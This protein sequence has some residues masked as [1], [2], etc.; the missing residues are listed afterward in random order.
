MTDAFLDLTP[1]RGGTAEHLES[2]LLRVS[3]ARIARPF[4]KSRCDA[5]AEIARHLARMPDRQPEVLALAFWMRRAAV[6]RMRQE[7]E[8]NSL[9]SGRSTVHVSARGTVFHIPPRNVDTMFA[10]SWVLSILTGN[11]N[12]IRLSP[13]ATD[14][15]RGILD[16]FLETLKCTPDISD[17]TLVVRFDRDSGITRQISAECDVRVVWGGDETVNAIRAI[18]L[19]PLAREVA[20]PD[21]RSLA[22]IKVAAYQALSDPERDSLAERFFNDAFWF[23]QLG[24]ASPR[25]VVWVGQ[26]D[27]SDIARDFFKRLTRITA[28]KEYAADA[29]VAMRKLAGAMEVMARTPDSHLHWMSNA[30]T[31]IHVSAA[32]HSGESFVGAG[33][34]ESFHLASLS[35]LATSTAR[36][37]QT[38]GV[39]GFDEAELTQFAMEPFRAGIDRIVPI[40]RALAFDR[41]WDG[42]NL[43]TE[44]TRKTTIDLSEVMT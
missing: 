9:E 14:Q 10:Y 27:P 21:R 3:N 43:L 40:G 22:A 29:S 12:I 18:P 24:C 19:P 36:R 2:A 7:F 35:E 5:V 6:E 11:R 20:F 39:F 13:Q 38:L 4:D 8:G 41:I 16:A 32:N 26:D 15:T 37:D 34:F 31:V 1:D 42:M 17:G 30:V 23:D 44:F 33:T 28:A 25:V